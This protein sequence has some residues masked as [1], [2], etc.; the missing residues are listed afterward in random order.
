MIDFFGCI[1]LLVIAIGIYRL[2]R[3]SSVQQAKEDY[4]REKRAEAIKARK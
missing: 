1:V 2:H 4:K 3:Q